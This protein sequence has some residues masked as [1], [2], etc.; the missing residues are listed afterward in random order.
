MSQSPENSRPVF[1][2][3]LVDQMVAARKKNAE[4]HAEEV[5]ARERTDPTHDPNNFPMLRPPGAMNIAGRPM[6]ALGNAAQ[7]G[8]GMTTAGD[9]V[10]EPN[11]GTVRGAQPEDAA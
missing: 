8:Q 7:A 3:S 11:I 4:E 1:P 9:Q 6:G 5:G 10:R 2:L